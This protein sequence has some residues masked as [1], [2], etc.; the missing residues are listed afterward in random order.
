L[1]RNRAPTFLSGRVFTAQEIEEIQETV[2]VF[3]R[4]NWTELVLTVCEHLQWVTP[5]GRYKVASCGQALVRL[6]RLAL[7]KLPGRRRGRGPEA[8]VAVGSGTEP[9]E[10]VVGTVRDVA[11]V[12]L[13]PVRAQEGMRLWN[14]YVHRYHPLGYR[15]PFGAHQRYFLVG[16]G[17]RRLGCLL[18]AAAAWALRQRDEWIGWAER[19]RAQRLNWVVANTRL[20]LFPWVQVKNLASKA[21]SLAAHRIAAD[22][23]ERY[24]Y[25]PVLL[26]TFVDLE[27]YRG[28]CYQAANWTRLGVTQG[29]GRMDRKQQYLS[30]P[31]AIYVY[32]L[33]TEFRSVLQGAVG[34]GRRRNG[35]GQPS[36]AAGITATATPSRETGAE[37]G[38]PPAAGAASRARAEASASRHDPEREE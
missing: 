16:S 31:R 15:R 37:T 4:L 6:E 11:P 22:W 35:S 26:E 14:E 25:A 23:Q 33:V 8:A 32:P 10:K 27:H 30:T 20:L 3:R 38:G 12:E 24:G 13:E 21:L 36:R 7:V 1:I 18:F 5:T 28:T 34:V 19:D 9:E 29:R 2:R 17:G